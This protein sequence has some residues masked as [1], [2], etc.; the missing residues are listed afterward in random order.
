[1][2]KEEAVRISRKFISYLRENKMNI[3]RAFIFGSYARGNHSKDS[4]IDLAVVFDHLDNGFLMQ[5]RLMQIGRKLDSR[6]EP[7]PFSEQDFKTANPFAGEIMSH[8][9][10]VA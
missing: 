5:I 3:T 2:D 4:D 9:L 10:K 8:G 1:M 7:H 6:I